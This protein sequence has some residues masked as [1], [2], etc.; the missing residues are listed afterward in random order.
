MNAF[1][2]K[3]ITIKCPFTNKIISTNNYFILTEDNGNGQPRTICNYYFA[4]ER[5]IVG[6]NLGL[7]AINGKGG[8]G[9][10]HLGLAYVVNLHNKKIL[11]IGQSQYQVEIESE[12]F[13][14]LINVA[15]N[16]YET[17]QQ[18]KSTIVSGMQ[19]NIGHNMQNELTG[20]YLLDAHNVLQH[21]D[22]V[23]IGHSDVFDAKCIFEKYIK[24][25]QTKYNLNEYHGVWKKGVCLSYNHTFISNRVVNYLRS[26]FETRMLTDNTNEDV[27]RIKEDAEYIKKTHCPIL[28]VSVR[29]SSYRVINQDEFFIY[30]INK[31][32]LKH[33]NI[34]ILFDGFT[35]HSN[36]KNTELAMGCYNTSYSDS[37]AQHIDLVKKITQNINTQNYRSL[38]GLPYYY[39]LQYTDLSTAS[40]SHIGSGIMISYSMSKPN[41]VYF[42][43]KDCSAYLESDLIVLEYTGCHECVDNK[44]IEYD[45]KHNISNI[46][47]DVVLSRIEKYL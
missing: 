45:D 21:I 42:G 26:H 36:N 37:K 12:Y 24:D 34:F 22:T 13:K 14:S 39:I 28:H 25:I 1:I 17:F 15:N 43:R 2:N 5:L 19:Q 6:F 46:D 32:V 30:I 41:Y 47:K 33:P 35:G 7:S 16:F 27:Q 4:N 38:I 10:M 40:L 23:L 3:C 29:L 44:Y 9:P 8:G 31:L 20:I 18:P 11:N